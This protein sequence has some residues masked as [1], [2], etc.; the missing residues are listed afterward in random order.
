MLRRPPSR[1]PWRSESLR[2]PRRSGLRPGPGTGR[3]SP[4]RS[5]ETSSRASSP[6]PER[7]SGCSFFDHDARNAARPGVAGPHHANVDVRRAPARNKR[8]CTVEHVV[9][10]FAHRTVFRLA[11]SEPHR[12]RQAIAREVLHGAEL[13]RKR[14][15]CAGPRRRRSSTPPCVDRDIGRV[16]V[17]PCASSSKM[18]VA[19]SLDKA[20]PRHRRA[21]RCRR[22]RALPPC[23]AYRREDLPSSHARACGIISLRAKSRAVS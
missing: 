17:Q 20:E 9:V 15:R 13:R 11:A 4:W 14:R 10:A 12:V 21:R 5:A 2:L 23:E 16:D 22:N 19:S 1:P 3:T 8:L 7:Q 6:G 18:M